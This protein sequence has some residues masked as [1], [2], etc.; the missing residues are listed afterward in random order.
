[1]RHDFVSTY[2]YIIVYVSTVNVLNSLSFGYEL[3]MQPYMEKLNI[4]RIVRH[5]IIPSDY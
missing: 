4:L 2:V 1:M 3:C 5:V